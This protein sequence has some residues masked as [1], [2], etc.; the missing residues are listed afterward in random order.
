M[1]IKIGDGGY[2][3]QIAAEYA[4]KQALERFLQALAIEERRNR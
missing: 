1:G 4:G 3:S 2:Q